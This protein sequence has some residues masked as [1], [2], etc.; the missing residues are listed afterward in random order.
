MRLCRREGR[1]SRRT[2]ADPCCA[3]ERVKKVSIFQV[4]VVFRG[5]A[6][7]RFVGKPEGGQ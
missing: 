3:L 4:S 2:T 1:R 5:G 6:S 7:T